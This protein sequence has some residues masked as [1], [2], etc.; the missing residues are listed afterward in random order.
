LN[1]SV[2]ADQVIQRTMRATCIFV[3]IS[4]G[5]CVGVRYSHN[6]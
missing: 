2:S 5:G 1:V 4:D 3:F 6:R